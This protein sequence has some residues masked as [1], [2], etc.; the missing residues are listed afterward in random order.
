LSLVNQDKPATS[1]FS[2]FIDAGKQG[3]A[4]SQFRFQCEYGDQANQSE[5]ANALTWLS[6]LGWHARRQ[7]HIDLTQ[8]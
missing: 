1:R 3:K 4:V 8:A 6:L 7:P 5:D 2:V